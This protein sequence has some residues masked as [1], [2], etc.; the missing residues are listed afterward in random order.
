[1]EFNKAHNIKGL[2]VLSDNVIWLWEKDKSVVVIDPPVHE[3]VIRYINENDFH[4]KAILQTHHHSDHIGGTKNL[5]E[6]WPDVKVIAS[7]KEKKRI[8]FQNVSVE[9]G[10]TLNILGEK[11][12]IIEVLGHTNSH[13]SFFVNG[14]NPVL[15]IGDTLFS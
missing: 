6:R 3:P 14:N 5:I 7:S 9:D 1:M 15:F 2:R 11:V 12:E 13:I 4:L 10:E 8:P